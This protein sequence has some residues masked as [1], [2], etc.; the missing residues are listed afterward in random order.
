M[1]K[2]KTVLTLGVADYMISYDDIIQ[3]SPFVQMSQTI[4]EKRFVRFHGAQ[5]EKTMGFD[6]AIF[7]FKKGSGV[8]YRIF[9]VYYL[10][11]KPV[12]VFEEEKI[13]I[14]IHKET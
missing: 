6:G 7:A 9:D 14:N 2:L 12:A 1:K 4:A 8:P 11:D 13:I 10:K 5:G 3:G